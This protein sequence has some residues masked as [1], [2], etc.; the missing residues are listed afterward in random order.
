MGD[1]FILRI[2]AGPRVAPAP[3]F[4][5]VGGRLWGGVG[6]PAWLP[7]PRRSAARWPSRS[8]AATCCSQGP[9]CRTVMITRAPP[10]R[11]RPIGLIMPIRPIVTGPGVAT[12]TP[13][14]GTLTGRPAP[15]SRPVAG[16][17]LRREHPSNTIRTPSTWPTPTW[18]PSWGRPAS[19]CCWQPAGSRRPLQPAPMTRP[20]DCV[21]GHSRGRPA[22]ACP[23]TTLSCRTCSVFDFADIPRAPAPSPSR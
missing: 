23:R 15:L 18:W 16:P 9:R 13:H 20:P 10:A 8:S 5:R 3:D 21:P 17:M 2:V 4:P 11:R 22:T 1:R 19:P 12:A 7:R 14:T 6:S